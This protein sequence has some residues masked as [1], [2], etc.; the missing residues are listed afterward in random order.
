MLASVSRPSLAVLSGSRHLSKPHRVWCTAAQRSKVGQPQPHGVKHSAAPPPDAWWGLSLFPLQVVGAASLLLSAQAHGITCSVRQM[1]L[2]FLRVK[3]AQ[4]GV[5]R[6]ALVMDEV[7][8]IDMPRPFPLLCAL[9]TNP[10][11]HV[12]TSV[13][14]VACSRARLNTLNL[15]VL[16]GESPAAVWAPSVHSVCRFG[17]QVHAGRDGWPGQGHSWIPLQRRAGRVP[18]VLRCH[19][20]SRLTPLPR[21]RHPPDSG[22]AG[23]AGARDARDRQRP[24][25]CHVRGC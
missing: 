18:A 23:G 5:M 2:A 25:P 9:C 22:P 21:P 16:T 3:Y 15:W 13:C 8:L 1:A 19:S 14:D 6:N 11:A 24:H 10:C 12:C 17:L 20:A 7:S 4:W